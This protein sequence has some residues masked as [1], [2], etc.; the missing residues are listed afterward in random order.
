MHSV[1]DGC[2]LLFV[3]PFVMTNVDSMINTK[4]QMLCNEVVINRQEDRW[5]MGD[6]IAINWLIDVGCTLADVGGGGSTVNTGLRR[7]RFYVS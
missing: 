2:Y 7:T 3:S 4:C 5:K 6:G 1:G